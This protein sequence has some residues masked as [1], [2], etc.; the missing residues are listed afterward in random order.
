VNNNLPLHLSSY[1]GRE[2]EIAEIENLLADHRLLTLTGP[3][4]CGKT[5]LAG[6]LVET[7]EGITLRPFL[8]LLELRLGLV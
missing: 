8:L 1:I 3:G 4:G 2:R 6:D 7:F 5:R